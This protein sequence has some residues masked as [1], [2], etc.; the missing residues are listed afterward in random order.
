MTTAKSLNGAGPKCIRFG[1]CPEKKMTC[2]EFEK[3]KKR[4][5][6]PEFDWR[7]NAGDI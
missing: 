7:D 2:G 5:L 4:Y 6:N 1:K 3:I